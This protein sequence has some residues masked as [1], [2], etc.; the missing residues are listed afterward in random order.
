VLCSVPRSHRHCTWHME[1][2]GWPSRA[3]DVF[4]LS[5]EP[6]AAMT[7][8]GVEFCLYTTEDCIHEYREGFE[9]L[10]SALVLAV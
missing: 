1:S 6:L 3:S 10:W 8:R 4:S 2:C 9:R 7:F 5:M